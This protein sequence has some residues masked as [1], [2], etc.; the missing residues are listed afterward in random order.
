MSRLDELPP[1]QRA[2]LSLLL[3]QRKSYAEVAVLLGIA[4]TA[5]HD[6]AHAA[7]TVLAPRQARELTPDRRAEIADHVLG[8]QHA[9]AERLRTRTLLSSSGPA[10]VW[11]R[12]LTEELAGIGGAELPEI[13]SEPRAPTAATPITV[14]ELSAAAPRPASSFEPDSPSQPPSSRLGGALL[15]AA[16]VVAA[17][18]AVVLLTGRGGGKSSPKRSTTTSSTTQA[19]AGPT[20]NAQLP[21]HSPDPKSRTVGLVEVFTENGKHEFYIAAEH[22]PASHDFYYAVWLYNSHTSAEPVSRAPMV[23]SDD[24][25]AGRSSLPANAGEYREILLTRETSERPT[26][27]GHLVLR[28]TFSLGS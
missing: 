2:T 8:Q 24:K 14:A 23:G 4:E 7:L 11:A 22:L 28:G 17:V 25:L 10:R 27:P 1:D 16:I 9:I 6:R 19:S 12:A 15:L 13:P 21:L 26:H 18:V 3:R 20:V 5:V